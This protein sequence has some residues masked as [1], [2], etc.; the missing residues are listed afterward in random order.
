MAASHPHLFQT[1]TMTKSEICKLVANCF[2]SDRAVLQWRPATEEDL[3]TPNLNEIMVFSSFFQRRFCLHACNFLRG[4]L[5]HYKIE[6][7]HLNHNFILQIAIFVH[8]CEAFL[9]ISPNSPL[10][11]NYFFL[12]Y[13]SSAANQKVR[14][15]VGL[16]TRPRAGFLK[17]PLKNYLRGWHGTWFYCENHEP[18]LPSYVGRLPEF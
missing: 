11:K 9:G 17:L 12:K 18:N 10:L 6:L 14:G 5:D 4:L 1:S 7:V 3:P 16:Q 13:Q 15:G 2:L 8:L